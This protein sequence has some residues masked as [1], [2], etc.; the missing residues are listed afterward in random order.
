MSR[1]LLAAAATIMAMTFEDTLARLAV[2]PDP[3]TDTDRRALFAMLD[4]EEAQAVRVRATP[5]SDANA[6]LALAQRAYGDLRGLVIGLPDDLLDRAPRAGEW[7][8]RQTL[9]H[10]ISGEL[11]YHA[12]A[13]YAIA[14]RDGEPVAFPQDRR[15]S[16]DAER[17][18]RGSAGDLLGYLSEVRA[19][20]DRDLAGLDAEALRRPSVY[21]GREIDV[22]YRLYRFGAHVVEHTIQ[23]ETTLE[24]LGFRAGDARRTVRRISA[25]RGAHEH[26]STPDALATLDAE[27]TTKAAAPIA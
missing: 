6:I 4:A 8:L 25:A 26:L 20:S 15:P 11:G 22:R 14:R 13:L 3:L 27:H 24:A 10:V 23:C 16:P 21:G 18:A 2:R 9:Q 17:I 19:R 12:A 5:L 7:P 1:W